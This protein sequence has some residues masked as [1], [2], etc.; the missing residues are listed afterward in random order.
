MERSGAARGVGG[1]EVYVGSVR[2]GQ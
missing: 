1:G 2:S